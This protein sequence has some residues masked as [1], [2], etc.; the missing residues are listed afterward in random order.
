MK[1]ISIHSSRG[2]TG[3]TVIATNLA[4]VL[5]NRGFKVALLDVDFRAPS[6]STIFFNTANSSVKHWL[7]DY[8]NGRCQAM[9]VLI[10][11]SAHYNL[12]GK[13]QIGLANPSVAAVEDITEKSQAWETTAVKKLLSLLSSLDIGM[14]FD[15]CI[16]DT[17][18]GIQYSSLNALVGA[19]LCVL[20]ISA[21]MVDLNGAKNLLNGIIDA[22]NKRTLIILNKF[23][24][25]SQI[26]KSNEINGVAD[27]ERY[28]KHAI[29]SQIPCY[30]DVLRTGRTG[31]LAVEKPDN[32]FVKKLEE[33]ADRI[34]T[35]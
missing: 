33:V 19:N 28:L 1:T 15:Y 6:L 10:D 20:V 9:D 26:D 12:K 24:P 3:K 23:L 8:L 16:L 13:L 17:S 29:T 31:L 5:S 30:C 34:D 27:I 4:C 35:M 11:I 7:N 18:P 32:P 22:F 14:G 25:G 2:G 21:D